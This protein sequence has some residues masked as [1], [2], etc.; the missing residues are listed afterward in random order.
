MTKGQELTTSS[1]LAT[2]QKN[3]EKEG[4]IL[5][6]KTQKM[7]HQLKNLDNHFYKIGSYKDAN[8]KWIDKM[9]PDAFAVQTFATV[10]RISSEIVSTV[11]EHPDDLLRASVT[12]KVRAWKGSKEN[13]EIEKE[14]ELRLSMRTI[15]QRYVADKVTP[16]K[17]YNSGGNKPAEWKM[18]EVQLSEHGWFEPKDE[19]KK[20]QMYSYLADQLNF[21]DRNAETKAERRVNIKLLGFDWREP[22]E[23]T[24][25]GVE[26][27]TVDNT[28]AKPDVELLLAQIKKSPKTPEALE[29]LTLL[30]SAELPKHTDGDKEKVHSAMKDLKKAVNSEIDSTPPTPKV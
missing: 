21:L 24:E 13:P 5:G 18:D 26:Q 7:I 12:K 23:I 3:M 6:A 11:W 9:E 27:K 10:Q 22:E 29:G 8:N 19:E 25:E 20:I 30:I 15:A 1:P 16:K 28:E 4:I 17:D 14:A 2:M